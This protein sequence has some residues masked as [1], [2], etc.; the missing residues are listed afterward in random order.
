MLWKAQLSGINLPQLEDENLGAADA[1]FSRRSAPL[2]D[3]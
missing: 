1:A 3:L 2:N